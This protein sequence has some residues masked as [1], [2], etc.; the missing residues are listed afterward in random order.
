MLTRRRCAQTCGPA[1]DLCARSVPGEHGTVLLM[2]LLSLFAIGLM[3]MVVA[4]VATIEIAITANLI[5]GERAF[6]PADGASQVMLRDLINMSR[7][8]GRFPSDAELAAITAPTF[9]NI[10]G[11]RWQD[12][13]LALCR[14]PSLFHEEP[15]TRTAPVLRGSAVPAR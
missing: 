13:V 2:I 14:Q 1:G 10:E 7:S 15:P 3:S 11:H 4:Q 6:L 8:L 9:T 12:Y 5:A